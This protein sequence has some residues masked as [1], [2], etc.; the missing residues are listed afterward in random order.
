MKALITF[1]LISLSVSAFGYREYPAN[2][3]IERQLKS[4]LYIYETTTFAK[5]RSEAIRKQRM[6]IFEVENYHNYCDNM[7]PKVREQ[8][9]KFKR[10]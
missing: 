6:I 8:T 10:I 4:W 3:E 2:P 9:K 1:T 5:M 7:I